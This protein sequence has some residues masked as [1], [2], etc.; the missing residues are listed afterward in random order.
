MTH[1]GLKDQSGEP[2]PSRCQLHATI[3]GE[4]GAGSS[5]VHGTVYETNILDF[6]CLTLHNLFRYLYSYKIGYTPKMR[7]RKIF[8]PMKN[9]AK[10]ILSPR[11]G[12]RN[13]LLS[14]SNHV[15]TEN[16][17]EVKLVLC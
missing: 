11:N 6:D 3:T 10:F 2:H 4:A 15:V 14:Q 7:M 13:I 16:S 5:P 8:K 1:Q 9:R 12:N 17:E